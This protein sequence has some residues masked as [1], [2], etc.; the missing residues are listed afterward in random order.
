MDLRYMTPELQ[1]FEEAYL[2]EEYT[3][4]VFEN[5]CGIRDIWCSA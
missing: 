3:F 4:T 2:L 5:I 1:A